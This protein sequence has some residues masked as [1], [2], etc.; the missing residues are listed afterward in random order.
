MDVRAHVRLSA[1][2][3]LPLLVQRFTFLANDFHRCQELLHLETGC[4][5]DYI[6]LILR[7]V[8]VDN[9]RFIDC[10]DAFWDYFEV[11]GVECV[12][13]VRIEDASL[14]A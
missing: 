14:A 7:S 9:A 10:T 2:M 5:N 8:Y 6:E 3:F 1:A 12:E 11:G 4:K 13:V